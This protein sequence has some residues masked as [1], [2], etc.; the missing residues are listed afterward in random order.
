M[1]RLPLRTRIFLSYLLLIG[2]AVT[3]IIF[4]ANRQIVAVT[5]DTHYEGFEEKADFVIGELEELFWPVIYE[6]P[7]DEAELNNQLIDLAADLE[8]SIVLSWIDPLEVF[9]DSDIGR[10]AY[11]VPDTDDVWHLIEEEEVINF[12]DVERG[13]VYRTDMVYFEEEPA[14]IVRV[15]QPSQPIDVAARNQTLFLTA[16]LLGVGA[17]LL[18]IFGSWLANAL[19]RPLT[20]LGQTAREMAV[21]NLST[22]ANTNAPGEVATLA[23][24]FNKMAE[25]VEKMV[26][27]QRAFASNAAHE[28][29]TPLTAIRLRTETL[30]EDDPDEALT[31]QYIAEIDAEAL[32][33]SRL[34][35]DL[36]LLSQVDANR[37]EAANETVEVG[38]VLHRL[39]QEFDKQIADKQLIYTTV[40]ASDLPPIK[41]SLTHIQV[42][43]RNLI[44][45]AIKYTPEQGAVTVTAVTMGGNVQ[46]TVQDNGL[47]IEAEHLPKLFNRFYRVDPSRNRS[48]PGTGLGLSLVHSIVSLY[49][50]TIAITSEGVGQG[51]TALLTFPVKP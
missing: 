42:V 46:I 31:Q 37:L 15:G 17:L 14:F 50:G 24:D 9:F 45:N 1:K 32:R 48:I 38:R 34:V 12:E 18:L 2:L 28:L 26:A 44:E 21:G 8:M 16:A 36:R 11:D 7:Y 20:Q 41:A 51:T 35:E 23:Q 5:E 25:A 49:G 10:V 33:L 30:L 43:L 13:W 47:G 4:L 3:I 29:R 40:V 6:E 39:A 22:R 19:T 27:E